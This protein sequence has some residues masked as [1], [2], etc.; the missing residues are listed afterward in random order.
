MRRMGAGLFSWCLRRSQKTLQGRLASRFVPGHNNPAGSSG[1]ISL[2]ACPIWFSLH[3]CGG[4]IFYTA[5]IT[6]LS[7]AQVLVGML[8]AGF[9]TRY[10]FSIFL[11]CFLLGGRFSNGDSNCNENDK[12]AIGLNWQNNNFAL[13]THTFLFVSLPSLHDLDDV[14]IAIFTFYRGRKEASTNFSFSF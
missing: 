11:Q 10:V 6:R 9:I 13:T 5:C 8:C 12:Q 2:R 14:K 7:S 3:A 4:R 1:Y